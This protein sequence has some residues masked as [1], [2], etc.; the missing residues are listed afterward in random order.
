MEMPQGNSLYSYLKKQKYR[1]FFFY[2]IRDQEGRTGP[3]WRVGTSGRKED[4]GKVYRK[5]G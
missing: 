4:V 1:F 2:R 3:I 5:Y